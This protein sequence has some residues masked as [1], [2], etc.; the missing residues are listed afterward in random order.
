MAP[1]GRPTKANRRGRAS[2]PCI[3]Q[4][5]KGRPPA[6]DQIDSRGL[7]IRDIQPQRTQRTLRK[8]EAGDGKKLWQSRAK[9]VWREREAVPRMQ[10]SGGGEVRVS[11]SRT[12]WICGEVG[13]GAFLGGKGRDLN[14]N[15]SERL[16]TWKGTEP[17]RFFWA[18][19]IFT[20]EKTEGSRKLTV[21]S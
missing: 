7:V 2:H 6:A 17:F 8:N 21:K 20:T 1:E 15:A 19:R 3:N 4:T 13:P 14:L 16:W 9:A 12:F 5:H 10:A 11:R 18:S